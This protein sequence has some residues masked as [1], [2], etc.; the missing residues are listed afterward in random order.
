VG[1]VADARYEDMRLPIPATAYVPFRALQSRTE[2]GDRATFVILTKAQDP[3]TVAS[4]ARRE[5][6]KDPE[7]RVV[8]VVPQEELVGVQMIRERLLAALSLFFASVALVLAAVGLYSVLNYAVVERRR[9]LGIRIAIGATAGKIARHVTLG[10]LGATV[11]GSAAGIAIGLAAET[12]IVALLYQVKAGDP[13]MLS[14]P[15]IAMLT[16]AALA[17]VPPALRAIRLD[18]ATLLRCE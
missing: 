10:A 12:S 9:E 15:V 4:A 8:N 11:F 1:V 18:P 17:S 7:V 2:S 6:Q 16:A 3:M 13:W 5:I 14:G